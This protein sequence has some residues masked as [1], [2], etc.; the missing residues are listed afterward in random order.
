MPLIQGLQVQQDQPVLR[1]L[2]ALL[3]FKAQLALL[4]QQELRVYKAQQVLL[5]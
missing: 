2:L 5:G 3:E 4:V 1:A